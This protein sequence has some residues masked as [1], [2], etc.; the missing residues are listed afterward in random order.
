ME[1]LGTDLVGTNRTSPGYLQHFVGSQIKKWA[2]P[3][4]ESGVSVD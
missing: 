1:T 4:K 2:V 3:I